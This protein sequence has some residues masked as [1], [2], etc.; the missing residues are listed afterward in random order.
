MYYFRKLV[1]VVFE[2]VRGDGGRD[3]RDYHVGRHPMPEPVG[4]PIPSFIREPERAKTPV[5][6]E[7]FT[8]DDAPV[9][10]TTSGELGRVDDEGGLSLPR[11][12]LVVPMISYENQGMYICCGSSSGYSDNV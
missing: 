10:Q 12:E 2:C 9:V 3:L 6:D 1:T 5:P 8:E 4:Y 11:L 7:P